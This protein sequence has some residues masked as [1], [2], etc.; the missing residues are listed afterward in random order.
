MA[1]WI[2]AAGEASDGEYQKH[3]TT[4]DGIDVVIWSDR[5]GTRWE[6]SVDGEVC[7]LEATRLEDA[8]REAEGLMAE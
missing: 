5:D 7:L 2:T 4:I 1:E 3:W 6:C 8:Q